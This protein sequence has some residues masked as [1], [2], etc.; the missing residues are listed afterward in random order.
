M[1]GV[2][3]G[4]YGGYTLV[5]MGEYTLVYTPWDIH[6]VVHPGYTPSSRVHLASTSTALGVGVAPTVVSGQQPGLKTENNMVNRGS[7]LLMGL[8][9]VTDVM[10]P[11][12]RVFPSSRVKDV[13]DWIDEG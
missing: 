5:G 12:R 7:L 4:G 8:K 9:S 11:M 13:K 2:H 3:P 10:D 1:V 6:R